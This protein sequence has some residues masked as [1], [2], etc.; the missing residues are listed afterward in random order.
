MLRS[1]I[2]EPDGEE[3]EQFSV[4]CEVWKTKEQELKEDD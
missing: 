2:Y 4:D 1:D 3:L